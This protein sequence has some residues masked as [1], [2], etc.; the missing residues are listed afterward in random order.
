MVVL[1]VVFSPTLVRG[2]GEPLSRAAVPISGPVEAGFQPGSGRLRAWPCSLV[3]G[4]R[5][6]AF[7]R[8]HKH[9]RSSSFFGMWSR[10][11]F[12]LAPALKS[13]YLGHLSSGQSR[14]SLSQMSS[15]GKDASHPDRQPF[16]LPPSCS[17]SEEGLDP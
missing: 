4:R 1:S 14:S 6:A 9:S 10:V 3:F 17:S 15:S 5:V 12:P 16:P 2:A 13:H 8:L 11:L 7:C